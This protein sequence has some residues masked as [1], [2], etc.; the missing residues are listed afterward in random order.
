MSKPPI[1]LKKLVLSELLLPENSMSEPL[2]WTHLLTSILKLP[3]SKLLLQAITVKFLLSPLL[4][5]VPSKNVLMLVKKLSELC[6]VKLPKLLDK[7][8][9]LLLINTVDGVI[10]KVL[11][12]PPVPEEDYS[13]EELLLL[14]PLLLPLLLLPPLLPPLLLPLLLLLVLSL[15]PLLKLIFMSNLPLLLPPL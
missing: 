7:L 3:L 9:H 11:S 15:Q 10:I 5:T 1:P 2:V 6:S 14:L 8:H 4:L 12:Q 13:Q